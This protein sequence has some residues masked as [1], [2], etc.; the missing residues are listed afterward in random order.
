[1]VLVSRANGV[2][3]VNPALQMGFLSWFWFVMS[4]YGGLF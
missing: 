2:G 3:L 4:V 1:M